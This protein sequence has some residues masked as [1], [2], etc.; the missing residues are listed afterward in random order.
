MAS[1]HFVKPFL[2]ILSKR[3]GNK[4]KLVRE[5]IA[6]LEDFDEVCARA[7][8]EGY[9]IINNM[10]PERQMLLAMAFHTG[11]LVPDSKH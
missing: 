6:T 3:D 5:T 7:R 11:F 10:T 4:I 8:R 2:V 9:G 1:A